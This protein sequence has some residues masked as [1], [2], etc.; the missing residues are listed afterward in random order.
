[1]LDFRLKTFIAVCETAS[2]TRAA[3]L[4]HITQPAVSQHIKF[5]EEYYGGKLTRYE[6]RRLFLT[7]R[8]KRLFEFAKRITAD[9]HHLTASLSEENF[10]RIT[11]D[12]G[13]TLSIGDY[14]CPAI[15]GRILSDF[16][17]ARVKM[18]VGNTRT[19]LRMLRGGDIEFAIAEG[20]L[21]KSN[22][23][24]ELLSREEFIGVCSP[25]SKFARYTAE[26]SEILSERLILREKGS[27]TRD[28]FE[29]ALL[30]NNLSC[31][32]FSHVTE[33]GSIAAIKELV[34]KN[35]GITFLY[36]IACDG[37]ISAGRLVPLRINGFEIRR[38]F[39]FVYLKESV[40]SEKYL[41]WFKYSKAIFS[42]NKI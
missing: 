22:F 21:D 23:G 27:G 25:D 15:I 36:K 5:L 20:F 39:N 26:L 16:P 7:Q 11:L 31:G 28:I 9:C 41:A 33:V 1:M 14:V 34:A 10:E 3:E 4:L 40:H 8:G 42:E 24:V 37:D 12:F 29:Q 2:C 17:E 38:E 19:L 18:H 32:S 6:N 30:E 35:F 13:A